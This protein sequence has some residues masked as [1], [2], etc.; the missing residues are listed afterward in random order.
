MA[1]GAQHSTSLRHEQFAIDERRARRADG[2][3]IRQRSRDSRPTLR[4]PCPEFLAS[5]ARGLWYRQPRA[6]VVVRPDTAMCDLCQQGNPSVHV[7]LRHNVGLLFMRQVYE[8]EGRLC[9]AC[10]SRAF[11]KHQLCNVFLGWWGMI[12]FVMTW[13]FLFENTRVYF[14]ARREL[15]GMLERREATRFVPEG[16]PEDRLAPFRHNV[17]LRL[18]R[19]E[20]PGVV[21]VDLA[22]THQVPVGTAEAFVSG[23]EREGPTSDAPPAG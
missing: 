8:T 13:V 3:R 2:P 22:E 7:Q 9:S 23:V 1:K 19:G 18:R 20:D 5:R 21:A 14:T 10:L 11:R 4:E 16:S 6:V 15:N 12:S 17:R